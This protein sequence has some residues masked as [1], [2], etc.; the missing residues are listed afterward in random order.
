[1]GNNSNGNLPHDTGYKLLFSNPRLVKDLLE[2]FVRPDWL[3][4]IDLGSLEPF[5]ASFTTDDLRER[6]DDVIWRVRFRDQW[7][8]LYLLIEFQSSD[9]YFMAC[10]LLTYVGL[11]YQDIIRSQKLKRGDRLPPVMPIVVY[12][13]TRNWT[14]PIDMNQLI[15]PMHPSLAAYLPSLSYYLLQEKAVPE[16]FTD[17]HPENL[18]GHLIGLGFSQDGTDMRRRVRRLNR[19]LTHPKYRT[20]QR[21]FAIWLNRLLRVRFKD[22]AVPELHDLSEVEAMLAEKLTSWTEKWR[23][24]GRQEGHQEGRHLEAVAMLSKVLTKRFGPLDD[25]T[26][27][28][29]EEASVEQIEAWLDRLFEVDTLDELMAANG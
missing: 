6:H 4:E 17:D 8:Y 20:L 21:S 24:E 1:M 19:L 12:N 2:G 5:K 11:L 13:G 27:R 7:V 16:S 23:Q 25:L 28:R 18:V 22:E 3:G 10:R 14:G 29:I 9:D 15:E 26:R